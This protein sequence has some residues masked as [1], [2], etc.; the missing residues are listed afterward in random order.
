MQ[1]RYFTIFN[2]LLITIAGYVCVSSF[3]GILTTQMTAIPAFRSTPVP[4]TAPVQQKQPSISEYQAIIERNL[5]NTGSQASATPVVAKV[6]IEK[7]KETDLKLK[8]WGTVAAKDGQTYA[9]IEDTKARQQN[10]YRPGDSV[11]DATVKMVLREKIILTVGGRDEI[12][13]MEE[14]TSSKGRSRGGG[15]PAR[16]SA[17]ERKMPVSSY[18]RQIKLRS[19]Q[20]EQALENVGDLMKQA[21]I[22]P[23][24]ENGQPAG[25]SITAIKPN[26]IFRRMRLRNGDVITGVNG[27]TI[28]SVDDAMKIMENLSPGSSVQLQI[29]RRGREQTLDYSIE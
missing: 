21:K 2:L 25:V 4:E 13:A 14:T 1:N 28:E 6:D 27:D 10:L 9:V 23:H 24:I 8:L 22:R 26:A 20:I 19:D 11:Q 16:A 18:P 15:S 7:L 17:A 12:L 5:F 29:K 3:Y